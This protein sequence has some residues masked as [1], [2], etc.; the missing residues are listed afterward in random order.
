[1]NEKYEKYICIKDF[2]INGFIEFTVEKNTIW[3]LISIKDNKVTLCESPEKIGSISI[4]LSKIKLDTFFK[5][6]NWGEIMDKELKRLI[7]NLK[8]GGWYGR[9]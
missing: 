4:V 7:K 6:L 1:M 2:E 5:K 3:K 8:Y 9:L